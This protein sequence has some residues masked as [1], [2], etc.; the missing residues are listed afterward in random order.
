MSVPEY[1]L[2]FVEWSHFAPKMV[3]NEADKSKRFKQSLHENI[4]STMVHSMYKKSGSIVK[5]MVQ[6]RQSK[7]EWKIE[8]QRQEGGKQYNY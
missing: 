5:A 4:R 1:E 3:K 6:V 8:Q 2:K 7:A